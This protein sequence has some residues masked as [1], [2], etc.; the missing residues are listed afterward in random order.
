MVSAN[1]TNSA[2]GDTSSGNLNLDAVSPAVTPPATARTAVT[3]DHT[4]TGTRNFSVVTSSVVV[5]VPAMSRSR[6]GRCVV[7][8]T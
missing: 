6:R 4:R 8:T 5:L 2:A 7:H 1:G 3:P